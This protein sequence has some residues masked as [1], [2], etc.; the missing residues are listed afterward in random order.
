M[1]FL[2]SLLSLGQLYTDDTN[3]CANDNDNNDND[4]ANNDHNDIQWTNHDCIGSLAC[5]SNE[6]K[7]WKW[8]IL[9]A[10]FFERGTVRSSWYDLVFT[11]KTQRAI[12][13]QRISTITWA[14]ISMVFSWQLIYQ[15]NR[16]VQHKT[17][18]QANVLFIQKC[19]S[20]WRKPSII[21]V[22]GSWV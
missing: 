12:L 8:S 5:M 16:I 2:W 19:Y 10:W 13:L 15:C 18:T 11:T 7:T 21:L 22:L 17:L 1:K 14:P 4:D 20:W 3:D 6:P 9:P